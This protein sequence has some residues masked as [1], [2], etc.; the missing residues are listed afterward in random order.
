M[1][2]IYFPFFCC[3]LGLAK[4]D[5]QWSLAGN[6]VT[7][8]QFL[9][10]TNALPLLFRLNNTASGMIDL[11]SNTG[12]VYLGYLS[13]NIAS[14]TGKSNVGVG[15][16]AL[17]TNTS[18][19]SNVAIGLQAMYYN[20]TGNSNCALGIEAMFRN[21]SGLY[22]NAIGSGALFS[23]TSGSQNVSD[24]WNSTFYNTTGSSNSVLGALALQRKITGSSNVAIGTAAMFSNTT[25]S[26]STAVGDSA[27]YSQNG[28][29]GWNTAVGSYAQYSNTT[30]NS[31]TAVGYNAMYTY[32]TAVNNTAI[33]FGALYGTTAAGGSCNIAV[34]AGAMTDNSTGQMNV[35]SGYEAMY[36]NATG[37]YNT[38]YG[39]EALLQNTSGTENTAIGSGADVNA[40]TYT[41]ATAIGCDATATQS[42]E[43]VIGN[44][45]VTLIG[46]YANWT[47]LSDGRYKKNIKENVPGLVFIKKLRPITY[48]LDI[49][50]V[51][52]ILRPAPAKQANGKP[53]PSPAIDDASIKKKEQITY[54]GFVAQEV[55][56]SAQKAG[57]DFSGV[58]VPQSDKDF[59]GLSY[60]DFVVPLVKAVQELSNSK[61]SLISV[62]DSLKSAQAN[63]QSQI[64]TI[65]QQLNNLKAAA[66]SGDA[67][68][69]KQNAP[70]PFNST[71]IIDYYLPL[72][73]NKALLTIR[74]AAG[75]ILK[76]VELTDKGQGQ[77]IINAGDLAA[78]SYFYSLV[79]NDKIVSTRQMILTH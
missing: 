54:T 4:A 7:S 55:E 40:G 78:G 12:N 46:G 14:A 49:E 57:Y 5:A 63:M 43:A 15:T 38:A 68:Q 64:N 53:V 31:N 70:N 62:I 32:S 19:Y 2:K 36:F 13:G 3:I 45:S 71:T 34:G 24:G 50:G 60:G 25:T 11:S 79:V 41:N 6:A 66:F 56:T 37:N 8:G 67:P 16:Q 74:D 48:N 52:K 44:T 33:G 72:S 76:S 30:G 23:N 9:G 18:G 65:L 29:A 28:S 47:N 58:H 73:T 26:Y 77:A 17:N 39:S 1:K 69:L 75:H 27:L 59:Y 61:D 35:A 21:T 10:T 20:T 22:N 42:N 51:N